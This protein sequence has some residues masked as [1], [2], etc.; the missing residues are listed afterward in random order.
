MCFKLLQ[1]DLFIIKRRIFAR[2]GFD[3]Y[4]HYY[5]YHHYR[6]NRRHGERVTI[7]VT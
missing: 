6:D 4:H 3:N 2:L 1:E 5:Q 7:N